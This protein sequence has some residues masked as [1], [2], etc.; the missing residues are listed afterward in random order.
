MNQD[1][2]TYLLVGLEEWFESK[3]TTYPRTLRHSMNLLSLRMGKD[4][5]KTFTGLLEL[6]HQPTRTWWRGEPLEK[7]AMD[8]PLLEDDAL[9]PEAHGY[10]DD[11]WE[12]EP[13]FRGTL[14]QLGSFLDNQKFRELQRRLREA[15]PTDPEGA[16]REYVNLRRFLIENPYADVVTLSQAFR[17]ARHVREDEV[18]ELYREVTDSLLFPNSKGENVAWICRQCGPLYI[19]DGRREAVK[20]GLCG[21]HCPKN[22][23]GWREVPPSGKLRVL[24]RA[25]HER[26]A[27]P[28]IPELVLF[29]WLEAEQKRLPKCVEALHL[30][31]G[32][33]TY[34][35]Q[36]RFQD[37]TWALDVKDI[38]NPQSFVRKVKPIY[39]EGKLAWNRAFYIYPAYREQQ[40]SDYATVAHTAAC[41]ADTKIVN[42]ERFKSLVRE[43]LREL[44]KTAGRN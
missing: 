28:G 2:L 44:N 3:K 15:Y 8:T 5:P 19:R 12:D 23:G 18:R 38:Y 41:P 17:G 29:E 39:G 31:P 26:V 20:A 1:D 25:L 43:K 22:E 33:D 4:Y 40:R 7:F 10:L 35:I 6:F 42:D 14:E 9:S 16:Q 21:R 11:V 13:K 37:E 30:Y 24:R 36:I 27:A 32:I 34:D